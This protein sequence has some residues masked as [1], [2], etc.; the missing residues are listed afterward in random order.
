MKKELFSIL[1]ISF[2]RINNMNTNIYSVEA[3][4]DF[5]EKIICWD[6]G[7]RPLNA[8]DFFCVAARKKYMTPEQKA[9]T[10]LGNTCMM[11][12]A[13]LKEEDFLKFYS[14]IQQ[15]DAS[16]DFILDRDNNYLPRSCMAFYMNVNHT[17][18]FKSVKQF[19]H[20]V[21]DWDY[22][23]SS[24]LVGT[25]KSKTREISKQFKTIQ[26]NL[27]KSFQDPSNCM[28][29]WID[30]DCDINE[31]LELLTSEELGSFKERLRNILGSKIPPYII[32][33]HGGMHILIN[34]KSF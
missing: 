16:L 24:L 15:V 9:S 19:K 29:G 30:I 34:S 20:L 4:K 21:T 17:D 1:I 8:I 14:K 3:I 27:L 2:K 32:R 25:G 22:D 7:D 6:K 28:K 33:T 12:K 10:N 26:N 13:V 11:Q 18:I 5:Y 31:G 23:L